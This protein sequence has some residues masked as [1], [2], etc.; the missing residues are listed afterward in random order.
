M[1][2]LNHYGLSS[3]QVFL[4]SN[5]FSSSERLQK[6]SQE[7]GALV[8]EVGKLTKKLEKLTVEIEKK[9]HLLHQKM[10]TRALL[11]LGEAL[12]AGIF[13][14]LLLSPLGPAAFLTLTIV[15]SIS[16]VFMLTRRFGEVVILAQKAFL[17]KQGEELLSE[18]WKI[19][20]KIIT[21]NQ[22]REKNLIDERSRGLNV[23]S[24]RLWE[25]C[26][27]LELE[28]FE[29]LEEPKK[30]LVSLETEI[31]AKKKLIQ[32][33]QNEIRGRKNKKFFHESY[34]L[35]IVVIELVAAVFETILLFIPFGNFARLGL[36][37]GSM[38][39]NP[40]HLFALLVA[41]SEGISKIIQLMT[42]NKKNMLSQWTIHHAQQDHALLTKKYYTL[43]ELIEIQSFRETA[44]LEKEGL[45]LPEKKELQKLKEMLFSREELLTKQLNFL[46]SELDQNSL[47][48]REREKAMVS[49]KRYLKMTLLTEGFRYGGLIAGLGSLRLGFSAY[50]LAKGK[51]PGAGFHAYDSFSW[52][53]KS[54]A[55]GGEHAPFYGGGLSA[56]IPAGIASL[57]G[58]CIF[59]A[60]L[61]HQKTD[62]IFEKIEARRQKEKKE[63][64]AQ[65]KTQLGTRNS[66][67]EEIQRVQIFFASTAPQEEETSGGGYGPLRR[68]TVS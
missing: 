41:P 61:L 7:T 42:I 59:S 9:E 52:L 58:G 38:L 24:Q 10:T 44:S 28:H 29:K 54:N 23:L 63:A 2:H 50:Y 3:S 18:K 16:T 20:E 37:I 55:H 68:Q 62:H 5:S 12:T 15:F 40:F 17:E 19:E 31:V 57:S 4:P 51:G 56:K 14:V 43:K 49:F 64:E 11:F 32:E 60:Q 45:S 53:K 35:S 67:L 25:R 21:S 39:F 34:R 26:S 47:S 1:N 48:N 22:K 30:K 66:L 36:R 13:L 8:E 65:A 46:E 27:S 6:S 33:K